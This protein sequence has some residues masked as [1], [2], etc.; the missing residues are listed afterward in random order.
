MA[1]YFSLPVLACGVLLFTALHV[2]PRLRHSECE[3]TWMF[4]WPQYQKINLSLEL[5]SAFPQYGLYLY[6][7]S[8]LKHDPA[9]DWKPL[10]LRGKPA[11]YIPGNAGSHKQ[12]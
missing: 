12:G 9:L 2:I 11:L 3:M 7:E 8:G 10:Q 4:A 5:Q 1:A 6:R